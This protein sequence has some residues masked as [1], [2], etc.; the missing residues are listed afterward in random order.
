MKKKNKYNEDGIENIKELMI[1]LRERSGNLT[2]LEIENEGL[3][4]AI[5][6]LP[7]DS[8]MAVEKFFLKKEN[9]YKKYCVILG[10]K[11]EEK[12]RCMY[13]CG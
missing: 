5:K 3:I 6:K 11:D 1:L 10:P 7:S 9:L 12:K 8:K 2:V 13:G 4:K